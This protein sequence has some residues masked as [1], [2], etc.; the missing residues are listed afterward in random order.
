MSDPGPAP[1][2]AHPPDISEAYQKAHKAYG[3]VSALLIAWEVIGIELTKTPMENIEVILKSPQ[4][5]PYVL[6]ILVIYFAFRITVEWL[7]VHPER[8]KHRAAR[9][10]YF[11]AHCIGAAALGL[12]AVQALL[13]VQLANTVTSP[14]FVLFLLGAL[15]GISVPGFR[16]VR[17]R[18]LRLD[19]TAKRFRYARYTFWLAHGIYLLP[20]LLL[21]LF[22][23]LVRAEGTVSMYELGVVLGGILL[24][25]TM[26]FLGSTGWFR[27]PR[28][29]PGSRIT[30]TPVARGGLDP[31]DVAGGP[32]A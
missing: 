19:D 26:S 11:V 27:L 7:Q 20:F 23:L 1:A 16:G 18:R 25:F 30:S 14:Q 29:Q 5:V 9:I 2:G 32:G 31:R 12:Y 6:V 10:D 4:A 24:G 8:Q 15:F 3:L 17:S 28:L 22:L 21:V 13:R